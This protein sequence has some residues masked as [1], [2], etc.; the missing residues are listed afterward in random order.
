MKKKTDSA[1]TK[2]NNFYI[3][4][5]AAAIVLIAVFVWA[6]WP[7][8]K[9][10]T[11]KTYF[12]KEEKLFAVER[13]QNPGQSP[14]KQAIEELLAGPTQPEQNDGVSTMLP[15]GVRVIQTKTD[16]SVAIVDLSRQLEDYGGGSTKVEGLVAQIVYTATEIPG[17]D[18]A[19]IWVEGQHEVVLGGEGL[20][21]D[22]P[23]GRQDVKN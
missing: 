22:H 17:I 23:L 18:K 2:K 19:W 8:G 3:T 11:I 10:S 5:T 13:K 1:K 21:L 6:N 9:A 4:L 15:S 12:Y 14:L 16:K 7:L 20:V